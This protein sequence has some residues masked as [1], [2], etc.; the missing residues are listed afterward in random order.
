MGEAAR[1][2]TWNCATSSNKRDADRVEGTT[3]QT[4]GD[5]HETQRQVGAE[6]LAREDD[7][8]GLYYPFVPLLDLVRPVR[9]D[10][11]GQDGPARRARHLPGCERVCE[12]VKEAAQEMFV[13]EC[14]RDRDEEEGEERGV[15]GSEERDVGRGVCGGDG[16]ILHGE[17]ETAHDRHVLSQREWRRAFASKDAAACRVWSGW[18]GEPA[19]CRP[20]GE[21]GAGGAARR[22]GRRGRVGGH[23]D[24]RL[25]RA[26]E[27]C[28]VG[29]DAV[30]NRAP[31][32]RLTRPVSWR[33][34]C[35]PCH[36]PRVHPV[37]PEAVVGARERSGAPGE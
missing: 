30:E 21:D 5:R 17:G 19:E 31:S 16:V 8:D 22:G 24:A 34:S 25:C 33:Q 9:T 2:E 11:C 27:R 26:G 15:K 6:D 18:D 13:R 3:R 28:R 29:K 20:A 32:A 4:H 1:R 12:A 36:R 7:R 37:P 23:P 35:S 14:R 10:A